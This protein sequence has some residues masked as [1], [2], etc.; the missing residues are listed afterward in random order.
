MLKPYLLIF[1]FFGALFFAS[2]SLAQQEPP[3]SWGEVQKACSRV[4][5]CTTS[6]TKVA[7]YCDWAT[8]YNKI[9]TLA[10]IPT[11]KEIREVST[12]AVGTEGQPF[13]APAADALS[14][15]KVDQS[16]LLWGASDFLVRRAGEQLQAWFKDRFLD[17]VCENGEK[18][19]LKGKDL[20]PAS[21]QV[22]GSQDLLPEFAA[23]LATLREAFRKDVTNLP[24]VIIE[25]AISHIPSDKK[26]LMFLARMSVAATRRIVDGVH[27]FD[28][29]QKMDD[30]TIVAELS[31]KH[32]PFSAAAY[33]LSRVSQAFPR[34]NSGSPR[35]PEALDSWAYVVLALGVNIRADVQA[36]RWPKDCAPTGID[37]STAWSRAQKL[38]TA[39]LAMNEA[40]KELRTSLADPTI[41]GRRRLEALGRIV[42]T[43]FDLVESW[44]E[45]DVEAMLDETGVKIYKNARSMMSSLA[46][47][48]YGKVVLT[49]RDLVVS[50]GIET[51]LPPGYVRFASFAADVALAEDPGSVSAAIA[52]YAAPP[53]AYKRKRSE[54][55][56]FTMNAY[57]GL[58][59]GL[60]VV[61]DSDNTFTGAAFAPMGFEAG[62][63]LGKGWSLGVFV[64]ALDL[65]ALTSW[66]LDKDNDEVQERPEV[67]FKQVVSPG[68]HLAIGLP[69]MPFSIALGVSHTPQLRVPEDLSTGANRS[70]TRYGIALAIDVP[71]L[72]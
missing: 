52:S 18:G 21:C 26:D 59:G 16:A 8:E 40:L 9:E 29:L 43:T 30:S 45:I 57:L 37:F 54:G 49:L 19:T 28:A 24:G 50:L 63:A 27:P 39:V 62:M 69:D 44:P 60:E 3:T 70:A 2:P 53:G 46:A 7:D 64:Q 33:V 13:P 22:L 23:G 72:P 71:L 56:Y 20:F 66:R 55:S 15:V 41:S 34:D 5:N 1:S 11:P 17:K 35:F 4:D 68:L 58:A 25:T 36:G 67:G 47:G 31:C 42:D 12:C 61:E 10:A 38:R 48:N 14:W 6:Y 32:T 51:R 65:G